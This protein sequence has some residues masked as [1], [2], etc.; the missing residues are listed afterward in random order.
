MGLK[1]ALDPTVGAHDAPPD[2]LVSCGGRH[3]IPNPL[4]AWI[5]MPSVL[6]FCGPQC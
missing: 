5:L 4:G 1:Y 6:S 2:P 3:P